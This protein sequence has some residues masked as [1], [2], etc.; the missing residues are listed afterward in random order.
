[1]K[2]SL[3]YNLPANAPGLY[4]K[5][6]FFWAEAFIAALQLTQPIGITDLSGM[7]KPIS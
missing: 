5:P 6:R 3:F 2:D 4:N 7:Y 1:M